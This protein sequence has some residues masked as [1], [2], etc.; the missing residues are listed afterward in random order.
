MT[1]ESFVILMIVTSLSGVFIGGVLAVLNKNDW[2]QRAAQTV[3]L[4]ALAC[5]ALA[6]AA[7]LLRDMSSLAVL[8]NEW[9][10]PGDLKIDS[11][12]AIF[13]FL[14][15]AVGFLAVLYGLRYLMNERNHYHIGYIQ[16]LTALFLLGM[17]MVV[18]AATPVFFLFSWEVMS[19][20]S[21]LLVMADMKRDSTKPALFYLIVTHLGAGAILAG[22]LMLTNG[23]LFLDFTQIS[24]SLVSGSSELSNG[25]LIAIF[26]LFFFAFG[27]KAGLF[28]FTAGY[29]KPIRRPQVIFQR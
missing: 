22:F 19:F 5:G 18:L 10:F 3:L 1:A 26:L 11:L 4:V 24:S 14:V 20:A 23:S 9:L 15:N 8:E 17:Q 7:F 13:F 25:A 21:F 2:M 27:S 6:G 12:S 29:R 28:L 16:F